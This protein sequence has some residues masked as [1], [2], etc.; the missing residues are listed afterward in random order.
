MRGKRSLPSDEANIP[1]KI[2]PDGD[3]IIVCGEKEFHGIVA[4]TLSCASPLFKA[5]LNSWVQEDD[6]EGVYSSLL[7]LELPED[8]PYAME[9]LLKVIHHVPLKQIGQVTDETFKQHLK[10]MHSLSVIG[11]KYRCD[12]ATKLVCPHWQ[13]E[14]A[15]KAKTI[16][17]FD[18]LAHSAYLTGNSMLFQAMTKNMIQEFDGTKFSRISS[19]CLRGDR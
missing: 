6:L 8:E 5:L 1:T 10:E 18:I 12:T 2:H 4:S 14:L 3:I 19:R 11:N 9:M 16:E 7:R 13:N 17:D 15:M